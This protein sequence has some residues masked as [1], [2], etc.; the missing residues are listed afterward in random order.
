MLDI[1][2]K[3]KIILTFLKFG[4]ILGRKK[5]QKMMFLAKMKY[6]LDIPFIFVKYHYGPYSSELQNTI[7]RLKL[8][9]M[10]KETRRE[11]D[12]FV[13]VYEYELTEKG[14]AFIVEHPLEEEPSIRA[15]VS[16]LNKR[17]TQELVKEAY[18]Y[19]KA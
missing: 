18:K 4:P 11:V 10:I 15:L 13:S 17:S 3:E 14:K 5:F 16:D 7:D 1:G 6:M 9:G 2:K 12:F 8:M 19:V